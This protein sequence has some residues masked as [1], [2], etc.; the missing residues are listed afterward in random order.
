MPPMVSEFTLIAPWTFTVP[1]P[2]D[3]APAPLTE[4]PLCSKCVPPLKLSAVPL[5]VVNWPLLV[6]PPVKLSVP[7]C[8]CTRPE[9]LQATPMV[10]VPVP[11]LL[12]SV[13]VLAKRGLGVFRITALPSA[14]R[15]NMAVGALLKIGV[16]LQLSVPAVQTALLLLT[17][18]PPLK[19]LLP[20]LRVMPPLASKVIM[21]PAFPI[22]PP[23]H[24]NIPG[25]TM[26]LL[27]LSVP[28]VT[29]RFVAYALL[30]VLKFKVPLLVK[31]PTARLPCTF[32]V[33]VVIET[34]PGPEIEEV[35]RIA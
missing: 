7:V 3:M 30:S 16:L 23:V 29:V 21:E 19:F 13:P 31:T 24:A 34:T 18:V 8:T 22:V 10:L 1:P 20:P 9:L 2:T 5:G 26:V 33:P 35:S 17:I 12:R 32:R 14:W 4:D 25:T 6:P 27:A 15:S 11:A 28:A